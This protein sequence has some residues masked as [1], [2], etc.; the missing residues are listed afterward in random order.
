MDQSRFNLYFREIIYHH[1]S[2]KKD[3]VCGVFSYEAL[4]VE[5]VG[6]GNLYIVGKISNLP[7]KKHKSFDFL[8]SLLASAI[9]REFYADTR[10]NTLEALESAL[11]SANIYLTDF[12]K[13]GHDEWVGNL[14]FTCLAFSQNNIH[15]GQTGNMLVYLLRGE[16]LT[17]IARKFSVGPKT[18]S[19]LKT[20]SNIASGTLE[21]ND[22]LIIT[23]TDILD[24][25]SAQKIKEL[26]S[27]STEK[28]YDFLKNY[29]EEQ[30]K[31]K[32]AS[33]KYLSCLLLE[34][35]TISPKIE[36]EK[37]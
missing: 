23:T 28:L 16:T 25:V 10:K 8:L 14:D 17:N 21:E 30:S 13:R 24:I 2:A 4:N 5:E 35:S 33:M 34:A 22:K 15:I 6:L 20:F 19:P 12:T 26:L 29:L 32:E 7:P 36:R 37:S 9:K 11:Q 31:N 18:N 3:S 1:P 27:F